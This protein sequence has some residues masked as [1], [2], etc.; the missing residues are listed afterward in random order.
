MLTIFSS[1]VRHLLKRTIFT[2][3]SVPSRA[4]IAGLLVAFLGLLLWLGIRGGAEVAAQTADLIL[5]DNALGSGWQD[6]SWG[7]TNLLA[8]SP[9]YSGTYAIAV[10]LQAYQGLSFWHQPFDAQ[11]HG[12]LEFYIHGGAIGGQQLNV[13]LHDDEGDELPSV[14]L[15]NPAYLAGGTVSAGVWKLA[16]VPLTDLG[17]APGQSTFTRISLVE[18]AGATQ[19][20]FYVDEVR[21]VYTGD[22]V[23]PV[24]EGATSLGLEVIEL[25][26]SEQVIGAAISTNYSIASDEDENYA[27]PQSPIATHYVNQTRVVYLTPPHALLAGL[28]YT[29]T[30]GGVTD[31]A[32]NPIPTNT[33]ASLTAVPLTITI[34]AGNVQ[35]TIPST[36]FG[37]NAAIWSPDLPANA[38]VVEKVRASGVA[39]LRFPGG[40]T[41]DT[42]HWRHYEPEVGGVD[43]PGTTNTTEVIAFTQAVNA[44]TMITVNFG[45]GTAEEAADWVRFTNIT[46]TWEVKYW[47]IGNE[48]YGDWEVSWTHDSIAYMLGDA[49]HDGANAFCQAM[50]AVDPTIR[51]GV[52]GTNNETAYYS[53]GPA[54]LQNSSD[55][56]DF[57][58]VHYY[59]FGPGYLDYA[60]L[61]AAPYD[62]INGPAAIATEVQEMLVT[63]APGRNLD[64]AMTEYNS[65]WADP[66]VLAIQPVN[67]LFL[68]D[69]LG[70]AATS[71]YT[72]ANHWDILNDGSVNG[73]DYGYLLVDQG[74]Y[75]QPSYY[76]FPLWSR[77]GDQML[78]AE[79]SL[80][81]ATALSVYAGRQTATGV[82]SLLAINKTGATLTATVTLRGTSPSRPAS[83]YTV[84][85]DSLDA[86]SVTYNGIAD[87]PLDLALA[88]PRLLAFASATFDLGFPPYSMLLLEIPTRSSL[89]LPVILKNY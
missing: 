36:L 54:V 87:P 73:G 78:D 6:W 66:E 83:V 21:L 85:G 18:A 48:I 79:V 14:S 89:F 84:R 38:D 15:N 34:D 19:P 26:F 72:Y 82:V 75:R 88:S 46:H 25:T 10:D 76:I 50:K 64:L 81:P 80:N 55:C 61:L 40:S 43:T 8:A 33:A 71:G 22:Q 23:S 31:L 11:S 62:S 47:E 49:S 30:V 63:Y 60:G 41:A 86:T 20:T 29:A 42:F 70:Q 27:T 44:E 35:R 53:W 68:A 17:M 24:V 45:T 37:S 5:Y 67:A 74:N 1:N 77:F 2:L 12:W 51:V 52:V 58:V 57:Y 13:F 56:I 39:A 28:A 4:R 9:V 3:G 7:N 32:G 65:Y 59:A 16:S 69:S